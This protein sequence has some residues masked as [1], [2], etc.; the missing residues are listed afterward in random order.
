MFNSAV[1]GLLFNVTEHAWLS[2]SAGIHRI[3]TWLRQHDIDV[4]VV[5]WA[6]HWSLDQLKELFLS[7][8][9]SKTQFIGFSHM[10]SI[11]DDVL[12]QFCA[13]VKSQHPDIIIVSGSSVN[14]LF[15]SQYI[16]YYIQGFG[17]N[18]V[19]ELLKWKLGNGAR[20]RF[21]LI[22]IN[23]RPVINANDAYPSYPMK[24][25]L[26]EYEDRDF[27]RP[28]EWLGIEAAR[29]C[30][31][32][33]SFCN[34]PVLGVKGD[35]SRDADD[36]KKELQNNYN[37]W[38]VTNYNLADETFNDRTEK[39]TKFADVVES[40]NFRPYFNAYIRADLM[41]NRPQDQ[42][43]LVRMNVLGHYYGIETFNQQAGKSVGKGMNSDKLKQGLIDAKQ[44]FQS[45]SNLYRATLG[46]IVGLPHETLDSLEKTRQWLI[47]HWQGQGYTVYPLFIPRGEL[48]KPS[49]LSMNYSEYGYREIKNIDKVIHQFNTGHF[50]LKN[51]VAWEND[52]LNVIEAVRITEQW[53][54]QKYHMD[55]RPSCWTMSQK[56]TNVHSVDQKLNLS[57]NEFESL[58][59]PD[60]SDYIN[61]KLSI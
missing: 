23:G 50:N 14:P 29:G 17:E 49:E 34:F 43:E 11:W 30:K 8:V 58:K 40:L 22:K 10:F 55:F 44:Y 6:N 4:E 51:A 61:S 7:R 19:I 13:W 36:F 35:Y 56:L 5:D 46:L 16:D 15:Q 48:H 3:A 9:S 28:H 60:I 31:F 12:E 27:I 26:I 18:A 54:K 21:S 2:R 1:H 42:Q 39:I 20:P 24:S 32:K 25:L 47:E 45:H 37:R 53:I 33:C 59:N 41:I 38:G 57:Y 52:H